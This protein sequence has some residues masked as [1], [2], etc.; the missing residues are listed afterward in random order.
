MFRCVR[1]Y[2][3]AM[4]IDRQNPSVMALKTAFGKGIF[5]WNALDFKSLKRVSCKAPS[6]YGPL[7]LS[8][9]S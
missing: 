4:D 2:V 3:A 7:P 9:E 5:Q 1:V 8:H 6:S